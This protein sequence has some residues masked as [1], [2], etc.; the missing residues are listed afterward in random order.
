MLWPGP[1]QDRRGFWGLRAKAN[2]AGPFGR[3]PDRLGTRAFA[4]SA[5]SAL[6]AGCLLIAAAGCQTSRMSDGHTADGR[7]WGASPGP[8]GGPQNDEAGSAVAADA[9]PTRTVSYLP[10][11]QVGQSAEDTVGRAE[12]A[13]EVGQAAPTGSAGPSAERPELLPWRTRLKDRLA[14]RFLARKP[15]PPPALVKPSPRDKPA[16][17]EKSATEDRSPGQS[18]LII[19][20]TG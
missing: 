19:R 15:G 5:C 18:T 9:G 8:T 3:R 17:E 2:R 10:T 14:A 4:S 6:M 13:S 12:P 11:R 1:G 16:A 7:C 20:A